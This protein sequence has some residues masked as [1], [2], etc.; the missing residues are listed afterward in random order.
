MQST[1]GAQHLRKGKQAQAGWGSHPANV[2]EQVERWRELRFHTDP[3]EGTSFRVA[4]VVSSALQPLR[5]GAGYNQTPSTRTVEVQD[6][7]VAGH[8]PRCQNLLFKNKTES[9]VRTLLFYLFCSQG[10]THGNPPAS[11]FQVLRF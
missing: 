1:D 9:K 10:Q 2:L 7:R 5:A 11:S 3:L 4:L 8:L 6:R